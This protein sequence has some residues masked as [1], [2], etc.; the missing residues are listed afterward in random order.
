MTDVARSRST[1]DRVLAELIDE[2]T[3]KLQVGEMLDLEHFASEY[4]EYAQQLR[5]LLPTLEVLAEL[6]ELAGGGSASDAPPATQRSVEGPSR[7]L[8]GMLGDFRIQHQIGRGGMGLVYEAEQVSLNRRVALKVLPFA[9]VLD[10]RQ[11]QRFKN[12]AQAAAALDHPN[13]V[14]VHSVG[15][16]RGV[17]YYAMQYIDGYTLAQ[18]IDELR[19]VSESASTGEPVDHEEP[20]ADAASPSARDLASGRVA[21]SHRRSSGGE[22]TADDVSTGPGRG[23][24]SMETQ[25]GLQVDVSTKVMVRSTEFF[26]FV[27]N[28]GIQAAGAL[29]HA[30]QVGIVHR[31]IKPSNLMVDAH[32]HLWVTDF[33]LAMTQ[34]DPNLTMTGDIL[35][36]LRYMSPE[37]VA[38]RRRV[39]DH[40]TDIYSLGTTLY[41]ALTLEPAFGETDRQRLM[42]EIAEEDPRPPG[43]INKAI[44]KDLETI[45]LRAMA[46]EPGSRYATA[47]ELAD[48]LQRFLEYKPIR[49]R[50]PS[51][52]ERAAKW[53]RRHRAVV[54]SA[55]VLCLLAVA[56]LA[57]STA[58]ILRAQKE[59]QHALARAEE[60]YD[61]A[62]QKAKQA[63]QAAA[64]A[65]AVADFLVNDLLSSAAPESTLGR[66]VTVDQLLANAEEKIKTAFTEQPWIEAAVRQTMGQ[67]YFKLG[68]YDA[69]G[70]HFTRARD[71]RT[72]HLD[73][74]DPR[75]LS[76]TSDLAA[77]LIGQGRMD[78]A[79]E[80][81]RETLRLRRRALGDSHPDT[82]HSM[83]NLGIILAEQGKLEEA[84]RLH[85]QT[86]A[87][88][89]R[90]LGPEHPDTL[91]SMSN[92]ANIL[93]RQRKLDDALKL[94]QQSV[95]VSRR[96]LG[97]EDPNTLR[98]SQNLAGT[99]AMQRKWDEARELFGNTLA[100]QRRVLGDEHSETLNSM[101]NLATLLGELGEVGEARKLHE[102]TLAIRRRVFGDV[103][104]DTLRSLNSLTALVLRQG[105]LHEGRKLMGQTLEVQRRV[106]GE[107]HPN[108]LMS[109]NDLAWLLAT[110]PDENWRDAERAV[111]L[112]EKAVDLAPEQGNFWNT[113]GVARYRMGDYQAAIDALNKSMELGSG[114]SGVDWFFLAMAQWRLGNKEEARRWHEKAIQWTEKHRPADEELGRF[115]AEAAALM[116]RTQSEREG[117]SGEQKEHD[118]AEG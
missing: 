51:L 24:P 32:G 35:G 15:C 76:S 102:E 42:R 107:E 108:T 78:E 83:G 28:L 75:T 8:G 116:E 27:A 111:E 81:T 50:R 40:R 96:V 58:L 67:T 91:A 48:D 10:P 109:M 19:Q 44:P 92:L 90:L 103:H 93:Q 99:L 115:R 11:L 38:G 36:T 66:A 45:V 61:L 41:E 97:A 54:A 30:H 65:E 20:H 25:P 29:E 47:Q 18:V 104:P 16:E 14:S 12:E 100:A 86:L 17:H 46:K 59:T 87:G 39:L 118:P 26:R 1:T 4:P 13:I 2:V 33:G 6:G 23:A 74:E 64:E 72:R 37:Q 5:E 106:H 85:E 31:D 3:K 84:R 88:Q 43:R 7:P 70:H 34:A 52:L 80:V 95:E 105:D 9:A 98:F 117:E 49:A 82:L 62:Q 114:G 73:P 55:C 22:A 71:L 110:C 68:R 56:G 69:A 63:E 53:S 89:R 57:T 21:L 112:A 113:L 77:A 101:H 94:Q 60:N 79:R